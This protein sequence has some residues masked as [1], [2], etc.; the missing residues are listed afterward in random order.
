M[1]SQ[2]TL[3]IPDGLYDRLQAH[4]FPGDGD[5][6]GAVIL[7]GV[8]QGPRGTRLLARELHL[9]ADGVDYVPGQRGYRMLKAEFIRDRVLKARNE[10]LVYLA[11]HNHGGGSQAAFSADDLRS[12]ERGYPALLD[13]T[14]GMPVGAL[15]FAENAIAGDIWLSRGRRVG[16]ASATIVGRR[17]QRLWPTLPRSRTIH[18]PTYDRQARLLGPD[19]NA[20]LRHLRVG[21]I[22]AGGVGSLLV[23]FLARLG[24]G[25]LVVADP[26]RVDVTNLPRL[27]G[28]TRW[29]ALATLSDERRPQWMQRLG[30][31]LA[32]TKISL[33]HRIARRASPSIAFE[34]IV[35][36]IADAD[37][38]QRY[39]DCDYLF[40]AADTMQARL[41]C[42]AIAHQYLIP[43]VQIGCKA[44]VNEASGDLEQ[45]FS[46]VR[47]LGPGGGCLWCG[48]LIS[49]ARLQQEAETEQE[50][51]QQR[52]VNEAGVVAPSVITLNAVAAAHAA[53]EFLF[54]VTGLTKPDAERAFARFLPLDRRMVWDE[55]PN[56]PACPECGPG[57]NSRYAKGDEVLLPTRSR[58]AATR[59]PGLRWL[60][61]R[62]VSA[63]QDD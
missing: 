4:L 43:G 38:A 40:L 14:R 21:I 23:E 61:P 36:D 13:I 37:V 25:T 63:E 12:H 53:N 3:T 41:V 20:L 5:E 16:L 45:V 42:N 35:G 19:G 52:Y 59:W 7:A 32:S 31:R 15:V 33:A 2:W 51:R 9:A 62:I 46:V 60:Y 29:D 10:R 1:T 48:Q 6:H 11:I 55:S 56:D 26:D 24:V 54:T 49:P 44:R 8:T 17:F 57:L 22:G 39:L 58:R 30:R 47:P 28:A 50:R 18:D 27:V 34:G